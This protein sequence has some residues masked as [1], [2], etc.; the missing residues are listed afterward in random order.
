MGYVTVQIMQSHYPER[1]VRI[2]VVNVPFFLGSVWKAIAGV[3]PKSVQERIELS[4]DAAHDLRKYISVDNIPQC[5]KGQSQLD[6]GHSMEEIALK[7]VVDKV[8]SVF[9]S[10]EREGNNGVPHLGVEAT[11]LRGGSRASSSS[12]PAVRPYMRVESAAAAPQRPSSPT[13]K[14]WSL[15]E[16]FSSKRKQVRLHVSYHN[17]VNYLTRASVLCV[18]R[19]RRIWDTRTVLSLIK[20]DKCGCWKT[21]CH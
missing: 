13:S 12:S 15:F 14:R 9:H 4:S 20:D 1:V 7:S 3:L 21:S 8:N 18:E 19:R 16:R 6:F 17:L 5:Y 11:A 2:V 10:T